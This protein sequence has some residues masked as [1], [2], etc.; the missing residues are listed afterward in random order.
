[1]DRSKEDSADS[2]RGPRF[3]H[4][5]NGSLEISTVEEEDMGEFSCIAKNVEGSAAITAFLDIK[6]GC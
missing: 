5:D 6:G 2:L 3:H 1:M 4:H